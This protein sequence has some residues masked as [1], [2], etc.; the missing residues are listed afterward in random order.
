MASDLQRLREGASEESL[1][2]KCTSSP[3]GK[4]EEPSFLTNIPVSVH[5]IGRGKDYPI[6]AT[7]VA[8]GDN[9]LNGMVME[10]TFADLVHLIRRQR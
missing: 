2:L 6:L 7:T 3:Y 8:S 4:D 5:Y 9:D 1:E 10:P